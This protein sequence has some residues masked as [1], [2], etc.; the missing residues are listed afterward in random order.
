MQGGLQHAYDAVRGP[1]AN[2]NTMP[3]LALYV[4]GLLS[5]EATMAELAFAKPNDQV[6]VHTQAALAYLT[7]VE[8]VQLR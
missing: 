1:V 2:D 5:A 8:K 7:F 3:T 6:S 4:D